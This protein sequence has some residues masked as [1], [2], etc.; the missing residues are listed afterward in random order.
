MGGKLRICFIDRSTKLES[1]RDLEIKARG[2][3]VTSLFKVTDYLSSKGHDVC[4][5]GDIKERG[6]SKFGTLWLDKDLPFLSDYMWDVLVCNRGIG[7]GYSDIR[8]KHRVLWTHD[9]P[10]SG[11]IPEPKTIKAFSATIFMSE[12]AEKIWRKFYKDIGKSFQIPNGVDKSIFYP[13]EKDLNYLIYASAP[14]RGLQRLPFIFDCIQVRSKRPVYMRAYSNLSKLHPNEGEDTFSV[15]YNEVRESK[16]NL[17]DPIPQSE[18]SEEIGKAG[19]MILPTDYPEICSNVILQAF[20]SGTPIVTT[21]NLGSSNEWVRHSKNGLLTDFNP[22]DYMV[23]QV[24]IIRSATKVLENESLHRKLIN[25]AS[26]TKVHDW[27][28]I[29]RQWEKMLSRLN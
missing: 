21:G 12:Y 27:S 28:E 7:S 25:G 14:N 6:W 2:G 17:C 3:M 18:F 29:G 26:K 24:E 10:H 23:Y 16:V 4:V 1:V 5:I 11:F 22:Q 20:A 9:L 13:R 19:L 8:A 15:V